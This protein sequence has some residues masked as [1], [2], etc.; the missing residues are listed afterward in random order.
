MMNF[1][2]KSIVMR[3]ACKADIFQLKR[4][5]FECFFEDEGALNAVFDEYFERMSVYC[6][7]IEHKLVAALYLVN[8]SLNGCKAHYLCAAATADIYR[9]KGIM[10]RL[11]EYALRDALENGDVYS[12]LFPANEK[13]YGFYSRLGYVPECFAKRAELSRRELADMSSAKVRKFATLDSGLDLQELQ[14]RSLKR[15][16]FS[17][18]SRFFDFA[19]KYY[20]AYGVKSVSGSNYFAL[21]DENEDCADVF[22]S[23]YEEFDEFKEALLKNTSADKFIFT[24][25]ADNEDFC[26]SRK[27]TCGMIK[28]LDKNFEIPPDSYVGITLN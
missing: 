27:E 18:E 25:K 22:Y 15:N 9:S 17:Y 24:L 21:I 5:W 6:A 16:Y 19:V 8:G 7:C 12:L 23:L 28:L 20:R 11:I 13:L 10:T 4:L 3:K 2:D 26:N 1:T 14:R